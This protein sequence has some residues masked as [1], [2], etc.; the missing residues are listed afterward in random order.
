MY[1]D[2]T[3]CL[4]TDRRRLVSALEEPLE[5]WQPLLLSQIVGAIAG[6]VDVVQIREHDLE[7]GILAAFT[8]DC[9]AAVAGTPVRIA[10][11]DRLDVALATG[12][13][14]VHL[15]GEGVPTTAA[16]RL[17]PAGLLIGRSVRDVLSAGAAGPADYLIAGSVF[18]TTSKPGAPPRLGLNGFAALIPAA[19]G[20]PVWAIGGVTA[21]RI[22]DLVARGARGV[23]AIGAF[24]P[25]TTASQLASAVHQLTTKLR[26]SSTSSSGL[27]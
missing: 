20:C 4:V 12:A 2:F 22:P 11:N 17:A 23:A 25:R 27:P 26:V 16:R 10:V 8:R 6:G 5:A 19:A 21:E 9:L 3:L 1:A 24:I 7:A 14:G 15:R 18:E 13:H